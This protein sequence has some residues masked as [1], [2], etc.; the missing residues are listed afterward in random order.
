[1]TNAASI[2]QPIH[3]KYYTPSQYAQINFSRLPKHIAIIPDGNRRWAKKKLTDI[4]DGHKEGADILMETVKAAQ[5]L[6]LK[7]ITFYSFSTENWNRSQEEIT[8]LMFL[9][10]LYLSEQCD[11]MIRCGIRLE[12]IGHIAAL[13]PFLQ[14]TLHKTRKATEHC[15]KIALVLAMNYGSRDEICRAICNMFSDYEENKLDKEEITEKT[16]SRY[17]DTHKWDD[18]ELL[19]RTSGELRISNFLLWQISYSEI[20]ISP[21]LWPDFTPDHLFAA[22]LDYQSRERRWGGA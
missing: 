6:G 7:T 1:M 15:N 8:G 4:I 21:V 12:T 2:T 16:V 17:L 22:I 10:H 5:E 19:I 18:P 3:K 11:E 9:F 14:D 13:P 20:H